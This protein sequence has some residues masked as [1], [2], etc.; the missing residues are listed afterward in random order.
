MGSEDIRSE[1]RKP[2][3]V[4]CLFCNLFLLDYGLAS[5]REQDNLRKS[6][7]GEVRRP[8]S[9][10]YRPPELKGQHSSLPAPATD[11]YR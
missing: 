10:I 7:E 2:L 8:V 5:L 3:Q 4:P 1:G 11:V 6:E 9:Q